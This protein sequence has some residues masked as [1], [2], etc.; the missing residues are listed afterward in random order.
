ML[1]N[2]KAPGVDMSGELLKY[3]DDQL[4]SMLHKLILNIWEA[5]EKEHHLSHT[6]KKGENFLGIIRE[7]PFFAHHIRY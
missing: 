7:Y 1:K 6:L 4:S 5:E 2:N 3:G